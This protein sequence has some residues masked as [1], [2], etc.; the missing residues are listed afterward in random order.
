MLEL[1]KPETDATDIAATFFELGDV[2]REASDAAF[3]EFGLELWRS[4]GHDGAF[5]G[6]DHI[7]SE[8]FGAFV[9]IDD[10]FVDVRESL[11]LFI[12]S[13]IEGHWAVSNGVVV[14]YSECEVEIVPEAIGVIG[15]RINMLGAVF[16]E[17]RLGV[18]LN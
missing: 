1:A 9:E 7:A 17:L 15:E 14:N 2:W 3:F 18:K 16:V 12:G 11:K 4:V 8:T 10:D 5:A 13:F 6:A